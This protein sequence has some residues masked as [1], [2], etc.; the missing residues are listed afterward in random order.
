MTSFTSRYGDLAVDEQG[1]HAWAYCRH[2]ATVVA[3]SG[4]IDAANAESLTGYALRFV[5]ADRPFVLDLTGST[6]L[7]PGAARL[8]TG[9]ADRCAAVGT[10][11]ALVA[12][13]S[14]NRLL[15]DALD[16]A[17]LADLPVVATLAEAEHHFDEAILG[18]RRALLSLVGK[19]TA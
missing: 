5:T 15:T 11:W 6:S 8:L 4:R 17:D 9:V 2:A 3:I 12:G 14:A 7:T 19:K 18:R 13:E 16:E 10:A 1:A